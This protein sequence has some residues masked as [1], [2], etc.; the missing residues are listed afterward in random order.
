MAS[1]HRISVNLSTQELHDQVT[2]LATKNR[3]SKSRL[4]EIALRATFFKDQNQDLQ[5]ATLLYGVNANCRPPLSQSELLAALSFSKIGVRNGMST[6]SISL[7]PFSFGVLHFPEDTLDLRQNFSDISSRVKVLTWSRIKCIVQEKMHTL[8]PKIIEIFDAPPDA[9]H[10]FLY[11]IDVTYYIDSDHMVNIDVK[12]YARLMPIHLANNK[13]PI[14][15]HFD[16]ERITYRHF[17]DLAVAPQ[18][19]RKYA[20]FLHIDGA[21]LSKTG[22]YFIGICHD[23]QTWNH[24]KNDSFIP[25]VYPYEPKKTIY[26]KFYIQDNLVKIKRRQPPPKRDGLQFKSP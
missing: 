11:K 18:N 8:L 13:H 3:I 1:K 4:V 20:Q 24:A 7:V 26:C 23:K 12:P 22:G 19:K 6:S 15:E 17:N 10:I 21:I 2:M 16:F 5:V 9:L 25:Y 14:F